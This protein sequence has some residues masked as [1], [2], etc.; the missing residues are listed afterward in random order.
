M[1]VGVIES[2]DMALAFRMDVNRLV[3]DEL[4][5]ELLVRG[6]TGLA[7]VGEMKDCLKDLIKLEAHDVTL[8]Y[9]PQVC[10][11]ANEEFSVI[12]GKIVNIEQEIADMGASMSTFG[13]I[14][15]RLAHAFYRINRVKPTDESA[16]ANRS[17][18][19]AKILRLQSLLQQ[20][21]PILVVPS[22]RE[23][24]SGSDSDCPPEPV[25]SSTPHHAPVV[26]HVV[27]ST[28]VCQW[29]LKFSGD[30][31]VS[32]NAFLERVEEMSLARHVPVAE[33]FQSA[34]DLFS[35]QALLWFR[36]T[37]RRVCSWYELKNALRVEF[38]PPEYD[39]QLLSEIKRRT[40]GPNESIGIYIACMQTLFQRLS[41]PFTEVQQLQIVTKNLT[42]FY[43]LHM[44]LVDVLSYEQLLELSRRLETKRYHMDRYLPPLAAAQSVEPDVAYVDVVRRNPVLAEVGRPP[45][46]L[47][48]APCW[49]CGQVGHRYFQCREAR[50]LFCTRCGLANVR[51]N[52]C[53]RCQGNARRGR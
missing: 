46:V 10:L 35:G 37:R 48:N 49:N 21:R 4:E 18:L 53:Q 23:A 29:D 33:L 32:V 40:Q 45:A 2:L 52:D 1:S 26:R 43:Q 28:P 6:M 11:G 13:L 19:I 25:L 44:G 14:R 50:R 20:K 39:E 42:P 7:T 16:R 36:A 8:S 9:A 17:Q 15:T 3:R 51:V 31:T 34:V 5:Y 22:E 47:N 24:L 30:G 27:R 38:Q 41:Q 12:A